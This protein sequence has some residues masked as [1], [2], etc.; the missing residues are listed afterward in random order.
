[1]K[2]LLFLI[3]L[4]LFF[5]IGISAQ[6]TETFDIITFKTPQ[7]WQ[8]NANKNAVQLGIDDAATGGSCLITMFKPLPGSS[9]SKVN[10]DS[11]WVKIVKE[12]VTVSG[13]P[14]MQSPMTENGWTAESGLAQY[15]SDG[16]KGL[17]L[18]VTIT[19]QDKMVNILILTDTEKFQS[20]I[21]AFLES[22]DLPKIKV[23]A[24][25]SKTKPTEISQPARKSDYKFSTTNFDDGWI[26]TEQED[27][28]AVT[29]GNTKVLIHYPNQAADKYNSVVMDGLKNAWDVL[30]AP[31]YSS[32]SNMQFRPLTGWQSIEFA[33]AD[34]IEKGTG[35][36]VYV[37]LFKMNYSNG[38]GRY[39]E[40]IMPNK[41]SFEQEFGAYSGKTY[42]WE[43][44]EKMATYNKFA[45]APSDLKGKW[46]NDYSGSLSYV[47]AYTGASAG[48]NTQASVQNFAFGAGN[49]YNWDIGVASGMV[50]NIKFQAVKSSGKFSVPNNWQVTF[51]SIE[52]KPRTFSASFAAVKGARILRLD[53]TAF[54]KID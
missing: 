43:K 17:V 45:V 36:A 30:V 26:G 1:M 44:M 35:K 54:G 29:K 5:S 13:E 53:D 42:G 11:A 52:G 14:Q 4:G 3:C 51:S 38:S 48:T 32:A 10:F 50:G 16:K 46:T 7:N 22:V 12:T 39:L 49:T 33:E 2:Q 9:D 28:V 31:R 40:F 8:K 20:E 27:W 23:T 25:E 21:A 24:V 41:A 47:N 18:L 34:M 37:V 6:K 15:E 19:G